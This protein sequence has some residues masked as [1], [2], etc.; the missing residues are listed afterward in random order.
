MRPAT[1]TPFGGRPASA[2]PT[3]RRH[4]SASPAELET[5]LTER[6]AAAGSISLTMS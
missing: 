4:S 2:A 3:G 1:L 5:S 6:T